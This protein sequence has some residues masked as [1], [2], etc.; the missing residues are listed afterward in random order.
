MGKNIIMEKIIDQL[1][2]M[3]KN[4]EFQ[5]MKENLKMENDMGTVKNKITR[6]I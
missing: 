2:K 6:E 3:E 5:N 1:K 4:I